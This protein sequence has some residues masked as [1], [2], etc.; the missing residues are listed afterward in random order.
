M[1]S[2]GDRVRGNKGTGRQPMKSAPDA[3]ATQVQ[4]SG[5]YLPTVE[6]VIKRKKRSGKPIW[7]RDD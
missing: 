5:D 3:P 4:A 7:K 1:M 2:L 6:A